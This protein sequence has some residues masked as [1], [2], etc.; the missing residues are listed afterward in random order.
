MSEAETPVNKDKLIADLKL[1]IADADELLRAT[2]GQTGEKL[3]ALREKIQDNLAKAKDNLADM[4]ADVIEKA[5]A[6]GRATDEYVHDHP[7][8]S[9][10]I[11]AGVGLI[12]GLL[13]SR[14]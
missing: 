3:T 12:V 4:Q 7:W 5:K 11:A 2:A 10:G 1:V 13:I 14:R 6:A 8:K 9:V